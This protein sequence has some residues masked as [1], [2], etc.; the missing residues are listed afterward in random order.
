MSEAY[1][2][3]LGYLAPRNRTVKEITD[4]LIRK[5]F[6]AEEILQAVSRLVE[7]D[8]VDDRRTA[9]QWVDYCLTCRPRGRDRLRLELIRRGID[10]DLVESVLAPV[11]DSTEYQLALKLL[12]P[13]PVQ[14]WTRARLYRFLRYRGFSFEVIER[15]CM[16][17][18]NLT[19]G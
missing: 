4:Y 10:R 14:D 3:A 19:Q 18:E 5:G 12:A 11:D 16:H 1:S 6:S 7:S 17:Y 13:R 2:R 15:I 8:L 9:E